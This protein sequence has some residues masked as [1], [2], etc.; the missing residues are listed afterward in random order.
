LGYGLEIFRRTASLVRGQD[1]DARLA[2]PDIDITTLDRYASSSFD[3]VSSVD[4]IEHVEDDQC[5]LADLVRI[6]RQ[7]VVITTPNWTAGRCSWPYHVRE[8]TPRQLRRLGESYGS[9]QLWKG[10]PD[11]SQRFPIRY[12]AANNAF[13]ALRATPGCSSV[14]R[15]LNNLVPQ[16]ARIHSHLALVIDLA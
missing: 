2:G 1:L 9:C 6:S 8:Y 15:V 12:R 10:T 7:R 11:G 13:N 3:V 5:F 4:V 16:H 14:T